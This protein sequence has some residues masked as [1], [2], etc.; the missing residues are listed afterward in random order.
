MT[1]VNDPK[2]KQ[3]LLTTKSALKHHWGDRNAAEVLLNKVSPAGALVYIKAKDPRHG[4]LSKYY[5]RYTTKCEVQ[6][7]HGRC[8]A[9]QR[10]RSH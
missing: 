6:E 4:R 9:Q 3:Q 10:C 7:C 1:N 5:S 2:V 8:G